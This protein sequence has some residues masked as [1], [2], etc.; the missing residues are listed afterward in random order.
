M[1]DDKFGSWT[2]DIKDYPI[3][4]TPFGADTS[5]CYIDINPSDF[6]KPLKVIVSFNTFKEVYK[7]PIEDFHKAIKDYYFANEWR[8][9]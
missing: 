7:M 9:K 5:Y 2:L 8:W 1:G 4:T 6:E 3:V